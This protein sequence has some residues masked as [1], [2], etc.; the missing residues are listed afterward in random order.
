MSMKKLF[1]IQLIHIT[2][3]TDKLESVPVHHPEPD[4]PEITDMKENEDGTTAITVDAVCRRTGNDCVITHVLT[5]QS[6]GGGRVKYLGKDR[7]SVV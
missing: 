3:G 7:K 5:I 6:A 2:F 4:F 1:N